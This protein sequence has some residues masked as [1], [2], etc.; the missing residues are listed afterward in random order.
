[1]EETRFMRT[2]TYGGYSKDDVLKRFASLNLRISELTNQLNETKA[3]LAAYKSGSDTE[4]A[5]EAAIAQERGRL[6][7]L[8]AQ[9]ETYEAMISDLQNEVKSKDAEIKTL[10]DTA[11]ELSTSLADANAKINAMQSGDDA[12]ALSA[13]FVEA[14]KSGNSLKAAAKAEADK[15]KEDAMALAEDI[16]IEANNEAAKII[17]EAEK[18]A[19]LTTA[20][21]QNNAEQMSVASNNLKAAML[22]DIE[23]LNAQIANIKGVLDN[24]AQN[25]MNDLT[26]AVELITG[27]ENTLKSGGVPKFQ[28]AKSFSPKLPNEPKLT[29]MPQRNNNKSPQQQQQPEKKK[30]NGLEKLQQM[31]NSLDGDKKPKGGIDLSAL[32]KQA[33]SLGSKKPKGGIDLSALQKQADALKKQ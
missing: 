3:Q 12:M 21:A 17:Y 19:A 7:E 31:A 2:V 30:N 6:S 11:T 25:G 5:F 16:V 24:F 15:A 33:D 26:R 27:T 9:N 8:Q 4:A 18:N 22:E 32:Q 20:E 10:Q 14:Q 28:Q 23:G 13:I 29:P 1:M